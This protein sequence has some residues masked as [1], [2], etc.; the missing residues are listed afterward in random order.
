MVWT[1]SLMAQLKALQQEFS[2]VKCARNATCGK[3]L[4]KQDENSTIKATQYSQIMYVWL[5]ATALGHCDLFV[6]IRT[7]HLQIPKSGFNGIL[8]FSSSANRFQICFLHASRPL[9][10]VFSNRILSFWSMWPRLH[11]LFPNVNVS[12]FS[13]PGHN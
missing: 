11:I 3:W 8:R 6:R 1:S 9:V 7:E 5:V 12:A 4:G 10:S 13:S 2:C